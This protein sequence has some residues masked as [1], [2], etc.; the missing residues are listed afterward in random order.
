MYYIG[1]WNI[2]TVAYNLIKY[3]NDERNYKGSCFDYDMCYLLNNLSDNS[4][5]L[6]ELSETEI[7]LFLQGMEDDQFRYQEYYNVFNDAERI[8]YMFVESGLAENQKV[9][10]EK[11]INDKFA[12]SVKDFLLALVYIFVM[13]KHNEIESIDLNDETYFIDCGI[14]IEKKKKIIM[15]YSRSYKEIR[16]SELGQLLLRVKPFVRNKKDLFMCPNYY[17]IAF[18][19][20]DAL[21]WVIRDYYKQ[22]K[23]EK[24]LSDFGIIFEN[25]FY[26]VFEKNGLNRN[27]KKIPENSL[28]KVPDF[29]FRFN[30]YIIVFE[31]KSTMPSIGSIQQSPNICELKNYYKHIQKAYQQI[32][33]Y[34]QNNNLSDSKVMKVIVEFTHDKDESL[35]KKNFTIKDDRLFFINIAQV[36]TIFSLYKSNPQLFTNILAK[37]FDIDYLKKHYYSINN[38][39]HENGLS[40]ETYFKDKKNYTKYVREKVEQLKIQKQK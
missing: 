35:L 17:S 1:A 6:S 28:Y 38:I 15:Y 9:L 8:I 5:G 30:E 3:S 20:R 27:I 36:E 33:T 39:L 19:I 25:Y 4:E 26:D 14:P 16:D 34:V 21:Y 37:I 22:I 13:L 32:Q 40:S 23:S 10:L 2:D 11:L 18:I 29:D 31:C 7:S 24:F 12:C